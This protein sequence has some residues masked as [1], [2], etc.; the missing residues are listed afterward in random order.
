MSDR[1]EKIRIALKCC[2]Q[3]GGCETCPLQKEICDQ[4]YVDMENVPA[5]LLDMIAE[6]LENEVM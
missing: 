2:R 1:R 6:E 3:D 4:L 5:E